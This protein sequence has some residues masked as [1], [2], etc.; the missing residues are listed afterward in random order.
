M[1]INPSHNI[2]RYRNL[3][4]D[5]LRGVAVLLTIFYH[6]FINGKILPF[7]WMGVD[8]FFVISGFLVSGLLFSELKK[9]GHIN[10][11]LFLIRRG[12]KIYPSFYIFLAISVTVA[13][14]FYRRQFYFKPKLLSGE[15]FFLQNVL[16][17]LWGNTWSLAV[18]EHFYFL[19]IAM[20]IILV[21]RQLLG[22]VQKI[23]AGTI[24][25][26]ILIIIIRCIAV[27]YVS[28]WEVIAFFSG[29]R[30]DSLF[31]GCLL[32][33]LFYFKKENLI[34]FLQ[35]VSAMALPC[36]MLLLLP[37][38]LLPH[39]SAFNLTIG[40][41]LIYI[42]F[43]W[44]IVNMVLLPKWSFGRW[45]KPLHKIAEAIAWIGFYS[46]NIYLWNFPL[47]FL[48][49][50]PLIEKWGVTNN[51]ILFICSTGASILAGVLFSKLIEIPMLRIRE[52]YF[53]KK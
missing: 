8:L 53:P 23:V 32:S 30:F 3:E 40:Y 38:I 21:R 36:I 49:I 16:G 52:K 37:G 1:Q 2:Q 17:R 24:V 29:F 18:E 27:F 20:V 48:L 13:L 41:T 5:V 35:K 31:F 7:G 46:Y 34:R 42:A 4:I 19:L 33:Y 6:R 28:R 9:R 47:N 26:I 51:V 25:F 12:F 45:P 39:R 44:L 11:K 43:G 10:G 50:D 15:L 14:L 22:S